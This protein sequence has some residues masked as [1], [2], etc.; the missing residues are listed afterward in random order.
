MRRD[1]LRELRVDHSGLHHGAAVFHVQMQQLTHP[2]QLNN[3]RFLQSH[4][5]TGFVVYRLAMAAVILLVIVSGIR[6]AGG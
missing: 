3:D 4:R 1:E 2:R 5:V 6:S